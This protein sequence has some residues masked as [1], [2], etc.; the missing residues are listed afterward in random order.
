MFDKKRRALIRRKTNEVN[1]QGRINLDGRGK[2]DVFTGFSALDH[3]LTLFSFHGLFDIELKAKGDLK[4]HIIEDIGI[5]LGKSLREALGSKQK[6]NRYGSFSVV[7]DKVLVEAS[8]DI[9]GRPSLYGWTLDKNNRGLSDIP[10]SEKFDDTCLGARQI[11]AF[12]E[13][14]LQHAG[15]SLVYLIKTSC[16]DLHHLLEALFKAL[17]KALDQATQLDLRRRGLPSTKGI[18]D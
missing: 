7:M 4:H 14:F 10:D 8:V 6:I 18:I 5:A 3:L 1:I 17:A 13:S 11:E 16:G 15:L 2:A 9:S 12:F